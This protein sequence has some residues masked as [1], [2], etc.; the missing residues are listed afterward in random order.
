MLPQKV[1]DP[2]SADGQPADDD[3]PMPPPAVQVYFSRKG[4]CTKAAVRA[5]GTAK[6]AILAE[7]Y[8]FT[9]APIA[10]VRS[11]PI[12]GALTFA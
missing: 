4:G 2:F 12:G 8:S 10:K 9:S 5:I 1:P 11:R 7:A 3:L 6:T